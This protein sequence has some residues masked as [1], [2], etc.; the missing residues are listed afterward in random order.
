LLTPL[1]VGEQLVD[2][3]LDPVARPVGDPVGAGREADLELP[4]GQPQDLGAE[5]L[6][7]LVVTRPRTVDHHADVDR[8]AAHR[9]VADG[10]E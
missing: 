5:H 3:R 4:L 6:G 1:G 2:R 9:G 7:D 10:I 8:L